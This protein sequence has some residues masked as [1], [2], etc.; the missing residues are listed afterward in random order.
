M[1]KRQ[2]IKNIGDNSMMMTYKILMNSLYGSLLI[3]VENILE[4]LK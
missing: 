1:I 4:L 2:N 3:R